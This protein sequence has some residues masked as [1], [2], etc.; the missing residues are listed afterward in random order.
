MNL[1]IMTFIFW[2]YFSHWKPLIA[3][4]TWSTFAFWKYHTSHVDMEVEKLFRD[5]ILQTLFGDN[6]DVKKNGHLI[7]PLNLVE[8]QKLN[9]MDEFVN[10][11]FY[12][13]FRRNTINS[14]AFY[15]LFYLG[16]PSFCLCIKV[17][18]NKSMGFWEQLSRDEAWGYLRR[19]QIYLCTDWEIYTKW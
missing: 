16:V 1:V 14:T 12:S 5:W 4:L 8:K 19:I 3:F 13:E 7:L 9:D 18:K 17:T 2:K 15:K 6:F 10:Q 11:L